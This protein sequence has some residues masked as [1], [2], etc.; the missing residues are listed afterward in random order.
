MES[1][2]SILAVALET[3]AAERGWQYRDN[4]SVLWARTGVAYLSLALLDGRQDSVRSFQYQAREVTSQILI[5]CHQYERL[6]AI[7]M[8]DKSETNVLIPDKSG[9]QMSVTLTQSLFME[10]LDFLREG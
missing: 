8:G 9:R 5:D 3:V 10:M 2:E 7:C 4:G 6:A 1:F